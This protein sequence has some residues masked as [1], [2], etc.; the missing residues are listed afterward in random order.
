MSSAEPV[1]RHT[2]GTHQEEVTEVDVVF[3]NPAHHG[4]D[5]YSPIGINMLA[6][7][8]RDAGYVVEIMDFQRKIIGQGFPWPE[9][10]FAAATKELARVHGKVFAFT[11]M[12]V[13]F[14]WAVE[15]AAIVRHLHPN[16]KIVFGGPH[17]TLLGRQIIEHYPQVDVVACNEG[18]LIVVPLMRALIAAD[19]AALESCQNLV[20]RGRDGHIFAT[21]HAPLLHDLDVLPAMSLDDELLATAGI[22]SVEAG[23]GCPYRCNFCSSH[24]IWTRLP[25]FKSPK[26]L[27]D[28]AAGYLA[29]APQR[30]D[31]LVIS[32]EHDDF[33]SNRP[34]FREF[35]QYKLSRGADFPYGITTRINHLSEE[36]VT[37]LKKSGCISV[38]MGIETGSV[39]IQKSSAKHLCTT[40]IMPAIRRLEAAR[41]HISTNF[42]IGFPDETL[43]DVI[44]TFELILRLAWLGCNVNIS[45]MCPEPGSEIHAATP[46]ERFSLLQDCVY[47]RELRR[48]GL[49]PDTLNP[50]ARYHVLTISNPNY[51]IQAMACVCSSMQ[52]LMTE[53]PH[54]LFELLVAEGSV[55]RLLERICIHTQR[56]GILSFDNVGVLA[57]IVSSEARH[58]RFSEF[59]SYELA[60][61]THKRGLIPHARMT[62]FRSDMPHAYYR[63][64]RAIV[65]GPTPVLQ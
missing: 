10:Y 60:K 19:Q 7:L 43:E 9:G 6:A 34:L 42:I 58:P 59:Y 55:G 41:L 53:F 29:A 39:R 3:V 1:S 64:I 56:N 46:I 25:R 24:A 31:P 16:A 62:D 8:L 63:A 27:V 57:G 45:M 12:N 5:Y 36:V 44:A 35:V 65:D 33:I 15:L 2:Q 30:A 4:P 54:L 14:P 47:A 37:L 20:L 50:I 61:A 11:I 28:E 22:L 32:Y 26:R 48:G 40:E 21:S 23:R 38:F 51:D 18:E 17:A 13:G 49:N 52:L